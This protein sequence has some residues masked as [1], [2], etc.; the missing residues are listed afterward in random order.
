MSG[1]T[2]PLY[3]TAVNRGA[4]T[5]TPGER[6][7]NIQLTFPS[8]VTPSCSNPY[9]AIP[10][11]DVPYTAPHFSCS[12]S[13][14]VLT[15]STSTIGIFKWASSY[16][17][18][19]N[20]NTAS[21]GTINWTLT[22]SSSNTTTGSVAVNGCSGSTAC[23]ADLVFVVDTSGSMSNEMTNLCTGISNVL[24]TL[25]AQGY[26]VKSRIVAIGN[27]LNFPGGTFSCYGERYES[28]SG[29]QGGSVQGTYENWGKAVQYYA[30]NY[31]WRPCATKMILPISDEGPWL[32]CNVTGTQGETCSGAVG[33]DWESIT[34][35]AVP[36]IPPAIVFPILGDAEACSNVANT[37]N[38]LATN[39]GGQRF[40]VATQAQLEAAIIAA[41]QKNC[42]AQVSTLVGTCILAAPGGQQQRTVNVTFTAVRRRR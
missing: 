21:L 28:V 31:P 16:S 17:F 3:F 29:D 11:S 2:T 33:S 25:S 42:G 14:N 8:G 32:G 12:V 41:V 35:A 4:D 40:S 15:L 23:Q 19:V 10:Q 30:A 18:P 5:S 13:S 1:A 34:S 7:N 39:T 6:I 38:V 37:M 20:V 26:N 22:G 9:T 24:S 27:D 36:P